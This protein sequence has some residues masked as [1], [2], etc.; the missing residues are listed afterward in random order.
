[1]E[2]MSVAQ[3]ENELHFRLHSQQRQLTT[4]VSNAHES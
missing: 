4:F 3:I 1:M 2:R